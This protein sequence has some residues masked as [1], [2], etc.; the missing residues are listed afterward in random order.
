MTEGRGS[1]PGQGLRPSQAGRGSP[2][3]ARGTSRGMPRLPPRDRLT[4]AALALLEELGPQAITISALARRA[5]IKQPNFYTYFKTADDCLAAA[6]DQ[7]AAEVTAANRA[8]FTQVRD[9]VLAGRPHEQASLLYHR[10]LI[11]RLLER[12]RLVELYVRHRYDATA[13]GRAMRALEASELER[14]TGEL[15]EWAAQ[16]RLSVRDALAEVRLLAELHVSQLATVLLALIEGRIRDRDRAARMFVDTATAGTVALF[17][18]LPRLP[19][20]KPER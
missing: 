6:A 2:A 16:Q 7:I 3:G 13:F 5:E 9:D 4:V 12:P 19:A 15:V 14:V 17:R 18:R 1:R 20:R 11:D 8:A 10:E